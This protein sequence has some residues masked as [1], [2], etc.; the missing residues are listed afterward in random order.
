M[1]SEKDQIPTMSVV[2]LALLAQKLRSEVHG[3]EYLQSEPIAIVGMGCRFPG[4]A[5]SP[6]RFWDLLDQGFDA[7]REVPPERWD[8][9]AFYD[10]DL[11][12]AGKMRTR[13]G[14]FLRQIDQFDSDFFGI[15][16]REATTMDPQQ[17]LLLEVTWEALDDA[18][19][20]PPRL[21]DTLTGV[22]MAVYNND[23]AHLLYN[24]VTA[25]DAHTSSGTAHSISSGRIGYLLDLKGPCLTVDTACSSS[26]VAVHM[27]VQGLRNRE[28]Q[29]AL[30]GGVNLVLSPGQT[31]SLSKWGMMAP[32][33]RCKTFDAR[34]DGFVRG[35]GCGVIVLKRLSDALE[36]GDRILAVIRGSAVNHDGRSNALTAPNG[37][38]QEAVIRQALRNAAST[39]RRFPMSKRTAPERRWAIRSK[40]RRSKTWSARR[41][42]AA[43]AAGWG[44]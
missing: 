32:D 24:D 35:E 30:A 29:T 36:E 3:I 39:R 22:Y 16:P 1:K 34:A 8:V 28:C 14:G 7:I 9:D 43:G 33:G 42:R 26:L 31:I 12:A 21:A 20:P 41:G 19:Y 23:Y 17:R 25:I 4:G 10:P 38:S 40:W 11:A 44:R 6:E 15:A 18:G 5:T 27:A 37:L 13:W 2:K